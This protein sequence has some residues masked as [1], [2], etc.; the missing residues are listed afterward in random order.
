MQHIA[1]AKTDLGIRKDKSIMKTRNICLTFLCVLLCLALLTACAAPRLSAEKIAAAR[2]TYPQF[3]LPSA[4]QSSC[5][6]SSPLATTQSVQNYYRDAACTAV[7]TI[8][9]MESHKAE[10]LKT[11]TTPGQMVNRL[12][13]NVHVDSI[14]GETSTA[15]LGDSVS[16]YIG[17]REALGE[18]VNFPAGTKLVIPISIPSDG[19]VFPEKDKF[20]MC[21]VELGYYVTNDHHILAVY[22]VPSLKEMEGQ[23]LDAFSAEVKNAVQ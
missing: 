1:N 16:L 20:Y 17:T 23:T 21:A 8:E 3:T 13:L 5:Y 9:S 19:I 22:D 10:I 14:M 12:Y 18:D 4:D 2:A 15:D 7:V 6:E 11:E